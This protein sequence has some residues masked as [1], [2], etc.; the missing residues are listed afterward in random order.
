MKR[1]I[2]LA[3]AAAGF[4]LMSAAPASA[5]TSTVYA[6]GLTFAPPGAVV[7]VGDSVQLTNDDILTHTLTSTQLNTAGQRLFDTGFVS[8]G[9]NSALAT[10]VETLAPGNYAFVCLLH[11]WM[12]GVIVIV[13]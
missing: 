2:P 4:T 11:P 9:G 10:G 1:L 7:H 12:R 3:V 5:A 13:Q 6:A 8:G